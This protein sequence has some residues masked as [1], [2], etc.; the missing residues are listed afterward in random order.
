LTKLGTK[1][2]NF[3]YVQSAGDIPSTMTT[4]LELLELGD[5]TLYVKIGENEF[6]PTGFDDQG[7][8]KLVLTGETANVEGRKF[9]IFKDQESGEKFDIETTP[10]QVQFDDPIATLLTVP[11]IQF[12]ITRLT[13]EIINNDNDNDEEKR[14]RFNE[15]MEE[16]NTYD[17]QLNNILQT[18]FKTKSTT[19]NEVIQQ[20]MD[21]K[22]TIYHFKDVLSE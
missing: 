11:Y 8:G 3:Q 16:A 2:G 21:A 15:I 6:L 20:C 4:T 22:N 14:R 19:R 9:S 1:Q 10:I 7:R 17:E 18:A 12:E 5:R 13:N